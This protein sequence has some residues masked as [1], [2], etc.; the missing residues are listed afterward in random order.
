MPRPL[1]VAILVE[2]FP[3]I[4]ETFVLGQVTGLLDRGHDVRI[5]ARRRRKGKHK[6]PDFRTYELR[7][8]TRYV[9]LRPP[10]AEGERPWREALARWRALSVRRQILTAPALN[11]LGR[12]L[13]GPDFAQLFSG[14]P[15]LAIDKFDL[16]H[17]QYGTL[18]LHAL[19]ALALLHRRA[20]RAPRLVV[21][22]RGFDAS[23][24]PHHRPGCYDEL[25]R[26]ADLLLPVSHDLR[27]S[28]L[29]LGAPEGRTR[30]H[31]SGIDC[32]RFRPRPAP[33][34]GRHRAGRVELVSIS[35][36]VEKK[37]LA[38]AIRAVASL[39]KEGHDVRYRIA[40]H[41]P[42]RPELEALVETLGAAGHIELLGRCKHDQVVELLASA[43]I[44]LAPSV[45]ARDR[46]REGIPNA[47]K[48]AFASGLPVVATRHGGIPE[49]VE[50]GVSGL[51]VPERDAV[52]LA[53]A[54]EDLLSA[55]ERRRAMGAAGRARVEKDFELGAL[56][57]RLEGLY[58]ALVAGRA[59]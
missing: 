37:G 46:N 33:P 16:V 30:V 53:R 12:G 48:E 26:R 7:K 36:H 15:Y 25:F 3:A 29:A 21:S 6:H 13:R 57:D 59:P 17:A 28:L 45:T 56:N 11:P 50:D 24:T 51:L 42:L 18:G 54:V 31:H 52:A 19:D 32:T 8:R 39:A 43:D 9:D 41:G 44:L 34:V 38:F 1:R 20:G 2:S 35:R 23:R 58:R 14:L 40:G 10:L 22:F 47:I 55:P 5:Y 49:L 4:S 27:R